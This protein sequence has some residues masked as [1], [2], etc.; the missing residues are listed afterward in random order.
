[1]SSEVPNRDPAEAGRAELPYR[2][3]QQGLLGAFAR[4]A[5]QSRDLDGLLQR[6]AEVCAE[7]LGAPCSQILEYRPQEHSFLVR[8]AAGWPEGTVGSAYPAGDEAAP[9]AYAFRTGAG[10]L[11]NMLSDS[12]RFRLPDPFAQAGIRHAVNVPIVLGE[13]GRRA[14]GVLEVCGRT[15][16]GFDRADQDFLA[17]MA[18]LIGLAVERQFG[19]QRLRDALDHQALL[20]REMSHRVKNSLGVVAGL[21]RLQSR[22]AHS[23]EVRYALE[24]AGARI[25]TV[26]Q[27]HDHLWRGLHVSTV[28]VSD[29]VRELVSK[30]QEA[31]PGHALHCEADAR[32][33][34]AD[35]AIPIGLMVN[36][37]VTNAVKYAY[38]AGTGPVRVA[39]A[40]RGDRLR[41]DV[42]DEGIGLP[43]D[44][45]VHA[46]QR[47]LGLKII[48]NLTRQLDGRLFAE[49][50]NPGA[51]FVLEMPLG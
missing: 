38:P 5:L 31:A 15:D 8:A 3:R 49:A 2:L 32:V 11:A 13:E 21:L 22:D 9:A 41:V 36:E 42:S 48:N 4:L 45:D 14:Y 50:N 25:A 1:M 19:E 27:V 20:A 26:A 18:A 23:H 30:L 6:A 46:R 51:R 39:V 40:V 28:E 35:Q 10:V 33:I 47:S 43:P 24:D 16:P 44:F 37:L 7:G 17:G 12:P 34:A 29:F